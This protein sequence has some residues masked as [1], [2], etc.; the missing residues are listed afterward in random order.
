VL[1]KF[2][3]TFPYLDKSLDAQ[4]TIGLINYRCLNEL[5]NAIAAFEL[6]FD[7]LPF[8]PYLE[9]EKLQAQLLLAKCYQKKGDFGQ[10]KKVWDGL[11]MSFANADSTG[12]FTFLSNIINWKRL[13]GDGVTVYFQ[14]G[15][16]Q[17][18]YKDAL[19]RS[20]Q[21]LRRFEGL[22]GVSLPFHIELYLY[23]DT[24][25]MAQYTSLE[26]PLTVDGASEIHT[27]VDQ[28]GMLPHLIAK[29]YSP[30]LNSRPRAERHPLL[31]GGWDYC[32]YVDPSGEDVDTMAARYLAIFEEP[33]SSRLLLRESTFYGSVEY[34]NL[35]GSFCAYLI[36]NKDVRHFA[37]L[38]QG[39]YPKHTPEMV[40]D[41]FGK[42]Y[43]KP[44][45][46][47]VA[48]WY[49]SLRPL[50]TQAK[51]D[52]SVLSFDTVKVELDLSTPETTLAGYFEA[53][54]NG[55]YDALIDACIPE[56]G[57]ILGEARDAYVDEGIFDE[58]II[59]DFIFPYFPNSYNI[60]SE[61]PIAD[62]LYFFKIAI[63]RSGGSGQGYGTSYAGT[64]PKVVKP[65]HLDQGP[66]LFNVEFSGD[67]SFYAVLLD[68]EGEEIES[69]AVFDGKGD[70]SKK[71]SIEQSG[72]Y[73]IDVN[74]V[75]GGWKIN[76]SEYDAGDV[77][78][79]KNILLRKI[80]KKWY[81]DANA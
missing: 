20:E 48:E 53:L 61:G 80:K 34:D 17:G 43:G 36:E 75:S 47:L 46:E 32:F 18:D 54:R 15:I 67:D 79:E 45:D 52:M 38:Y 42:I 69:L 3:E 2:T 16:S 26:E 65:F 77:I 56:L 31:R 57:A 35:A 78:E 10:E 44:M 55:D 8:H 39:L 63:V 13:T 25:E 28:A 76:F 9:S 81:V 40:E 30:A 73:M 11:V 64:G 70:T 1:T 27:T 29:V 4:M 72:E 62:D 22:F 5:D 12:R 50:I 58:I 23:A 33:P 14:S 59:M 19:E 7:M 60:L 74:C 37:K 66:I 49:N 21:E 51:A 6:Y 41:L 24:T 71:I 68:D